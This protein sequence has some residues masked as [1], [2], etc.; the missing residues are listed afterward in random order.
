MEFGY[1]ESLSPESTMHHR[2][3]R[4][5]QAGCR[6]IMTHRA[7]WAWLCL[8]L[9]AVSWG[10]GATPSPSTAPSPADSY[11]RQA[12]QLAQDGKLAEAE[13]A[14]RK[15]IDADPKHADSRLALADLLQTQNK[16]DE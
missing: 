13:A 3:D 5:K 10:K 11:F 14:L 7:H 15:A 8:L 4:K 12:K 1:K 9:V 6:G 2:Y 16:P